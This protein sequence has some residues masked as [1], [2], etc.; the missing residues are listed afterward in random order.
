MSV[1]TRVGERR[2][3]VNVSSSLFHSYP[4]RGVCLVSIRTGVGER[5]YLLRLFLLYYCHPETHSQRLQFYLTRSDSG[6]SQNKRRHTRV[7]RQKTEHTSKT[8]RISMHW[9]V[10]RRNAKKVLSYQQQKE[11]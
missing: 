3:Y 10:K 6:Q 5:R 1:R 11:E 4:A 9:L 8:L 7:K 2:Y